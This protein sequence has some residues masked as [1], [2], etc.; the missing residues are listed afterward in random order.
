MTRQEATKKTQ[1]ILCGDQNSNKD[2]FKYMFAVY[3][4]G[5]PEYTPISPMFLPRVT[6]KHKIEISQEAYD[7]LIKIRDWTK[8]SFSEAPF[9]ITGE[10]RED[11]TISLTSVTSVIPHGPTKDEV[12]NFSTFFN[13]Y[14]DKLEDGSM[15]VE[16]KPVFCYGHTHADVKIGSNFSFSD[17]ITYL[18]IHS[19]DNR[20]LT[21]EIKTIGMLMPQSGDFN[22]IEYDDSAY[23]ENFYKYPAVSLVKADGQKVSLPAYQKGD[24]L[25]DVPIFGDDQLDSSVPF[26]QGGR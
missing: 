9:F 16:G 6:P 3:N 8:C 26:N 11:G 19:L 10:E 23:S 7:E 2:S 5:K 17:L 14:V 25:D 15:Q 4:Y 22:F 21:G 12:D 13:D 1:E 24:Y 20:F 18:Q